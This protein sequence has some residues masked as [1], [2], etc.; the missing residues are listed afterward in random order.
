MKIKDYRKS[1]WE[2]YSEMRGMFIAFSTFQEL[3]DSILS[4]IPIKSADR[5]IYINFYKFGWA[6]YTSRIDIINNHEILVI[7]DTIYS[8]FFNKLYDN[9]LFNHGCLKIAVQRALP[10]LTY[11]GYKFLFV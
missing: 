11:Q 5:D 3:M 1:Y 7:P 8:N 9:A 10:T 6:R 4:T 2:V